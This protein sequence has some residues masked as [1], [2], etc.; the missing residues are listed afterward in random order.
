[1]VILEEKE[2]ISPEKVWRINDRYDAEQQEQ[3]RK[4]GYAHQFIV[5]GGY[6][7]PHDYERAEREG[8]TVLD[9]PGLAKALGK[10]AQEHGF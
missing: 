6:C 3:L 8:I 7:F 9:R 1:M 4:A 2:F 10:Y 5:T